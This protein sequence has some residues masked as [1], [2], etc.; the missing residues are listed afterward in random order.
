MTDS[1]FIIELFCRVDD[2]MKDVK[3]HPQAK[4]HPSELV[5]LGIVFALKGVGSRAYYRWMSRNFGDLFPNLLERTRF[6]P[7][8]ETT[9]SMGKVFHGKT[10]LD[11]SD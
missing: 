7:C 10:E 5:T 2:M 9:E 6:F 8:F 1:D 11:R 3:K 4:M